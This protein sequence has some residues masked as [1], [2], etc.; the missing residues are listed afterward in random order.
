MILGQS[1]PHISLF[2]ARLVQPHAASPS[3]AN[4]AHAAGCDQPPVV[5]CE[6]GLLRLSAAEQNRLC[7]AAARNR[8]SH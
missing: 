1:F 8:T 7:A 3:C 5:V 6:E 2:L 4:C